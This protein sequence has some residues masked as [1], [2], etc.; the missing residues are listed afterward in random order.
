MRP[1][2]LDVTGRAVRILRVLIMLWSSRLNGSDVMRHAVTRQTELIYCAESQQS[3]ISRAVRCMAG[4]AAFS[5]QRRVLIS[6]WPLFVCMTLNA[7]CIAAGGQARLFKF[8][9]A[10]RVMTI[11][12]TH[13]TFHYFVMEGHGERRLHFAVAT[14]AKL[15]VAHLQQFQRCESRFF[16]I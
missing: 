15:W 9:T 2:D 1:V 8:E 3:W 7:S 14:E 11:A 4:H 10:V 6:E 5:F 13:R 16:S 12:A